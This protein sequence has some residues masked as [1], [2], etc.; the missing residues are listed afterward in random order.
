MQFDWQT[1]LWVAIGSAT[2]IGTIWVRLKKIDPKLPQQ[3]QDI[4]DKLP[5]GIQKAVEVGKNI[6][7]DGAKLLSDL[8]KSPWFAGEAAKGKIE[9]KDIEDKL[10]KSHLGQA[11]ATVLAGAGK[12]WASMSEI[13]KST[14]IT[15][16]QA[17]LK[18][19]GVDV[20]TAQITGAITPVEAAIAAAMPIMKDAEKRNAEIT[21]SATAT[22]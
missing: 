8:F 7:D 14:L 21:A 11:I 6:V 3:V 12:T 19:V 2:T 1:L 4:V 13:E 17:G 18:A 9:I 20:T 22:A 5:A 16:V 15:Q 10:L